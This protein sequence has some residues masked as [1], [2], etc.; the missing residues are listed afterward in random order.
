M[1]EEILVS[2]TFCE[3]RIRGSDKIK[4]VVEI[5]EDGSGDI[6]VQNSVEAANWDSLRAVYPTIESILK[7]ASTL[8]EWVPYHSDQERTIIANSIIG[9]EGLY[10]FDTNNPPQYEYQR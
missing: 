7:E 6:S 9:A 8:P 5:V 2:L 1:R 4:C 3:K 10:I